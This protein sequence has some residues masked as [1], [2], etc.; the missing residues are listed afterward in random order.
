MGFL[1]YI[2]KVLP[3]AKK[4]KVKATTQERLISQLNSGLDESSPPWNTQ[5][6][7]PDRPA[8]FSDY[9]QK[10]TAIKI[11]NTQ[12]KAVRCPCWEMHCFT[13]DSSSER[14]INADKAFM[15]SQPISKSH[16]ASLVKNPTEE[17]ETVL[18][19][20]W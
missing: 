13:K 8:Q 2:L 19:E 10:P 7:H 1:I 4:K 12:L 15:K 20:S 5:W 16:L 9:V 6:L 3:I 18:E 14:E 17:T 11:C